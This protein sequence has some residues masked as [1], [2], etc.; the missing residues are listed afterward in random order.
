[1]FLDSL[2]N[3]L[4]DKYLLQSGHPDVWI[5]NV[6]IGF[7]LRRPLVWQSRGPQAERIFQTFNRLVRGVGL[8]LTTPGDHL[9]AA[10]TLL[11]TPLL[12]NLCL[13]VL[14]QAYLY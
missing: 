11:D 10:S 2:I 3:E 14:S 1:M 8:R 6:G 5:I 9:W 4:F 7:D 12:R 13:S